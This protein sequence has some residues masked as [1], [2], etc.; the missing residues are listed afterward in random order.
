MK[1][2]SHPQIPVRTFFYLSVRDRVEKLLNSD[3]R[4]LFYYEKFRYKSTTDDFVEDIYDS[5]VYKKMKSLIP[6]QGELI[7]LQVNSKAFINN[8][9][10]LCHVSS[11]SQRVQVCWDGADMFNYSGNSMWPL[12]YSIMSL[13]PS[14]RD[15]SH[16]GT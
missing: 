15:K 14:L 3:L 7:F 1:L 16:I 12:C 5:K 13:P 10:V 4:N 2:C 8:D 6:P 11:I 9:T